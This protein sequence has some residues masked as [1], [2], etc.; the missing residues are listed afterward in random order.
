[1]FRR[2][3]RGYRAA[4]R[5]EQNRAAAEQLRR[6][7]PETYQRI[8]AMAEGEAAAAAEKDPDAFVALFMA[9][10]EDAGLVDRESP[11]PRPRRYSERNI[12]DWDFRSW[13]S[14]LLEGG[15]AFDDPATDFLEE[16]FLEVLAID[17]LRLSTLNSLILEGYARRPD[18]SGD[19]FLT[20]FGEQV[21]AHLTSARDLLTRRG[22][23]H[24]R[25]VK[26]LV[27]EWQK[28]GRLRLT[29]LPPDLGESFPGLFPE[30]EPG[31]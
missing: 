12:E 20:P 26:S 24:R 5:V 8:L 9:E 16:H 7:E 19:V 2:R 15:S 13:R 10:A 17:H 28:N 14:P 27:R 18:E 4:F 11:R 22:R 30:R 29:L 25:I 3:L 1:M 6:A 31:A 21:L 23:L